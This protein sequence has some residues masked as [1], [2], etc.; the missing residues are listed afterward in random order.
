M[1]HIVTKATAIQFIN[2][3][4]LLKKRKSCKTTLSGCYASVSYDLLL[5]P[6]EVD[7]HI[8]HAHIP[9]C[10]QNDLA[11]HTWFKNSNAKK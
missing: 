10:E 4:C 6:L 1:V 3:K 11:M 7:T 5:M 8:T 2:G 9:M